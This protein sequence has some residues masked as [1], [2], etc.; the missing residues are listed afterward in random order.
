MGKLPVVKQ[1]DWHPDVLKGPFTR[2]GSESGL[3]SLSLTPRSPPDLPQDLKDLS[4]K[5]LRPLTVFVPALALSL[6]L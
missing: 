4:L 1:G 5:D 2:P 6:H 3:L